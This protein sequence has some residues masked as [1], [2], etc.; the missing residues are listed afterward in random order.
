VNVGDSLVSSPA[1]GDITGDAHMEIVVGCVD[2]YIYAFNHQGSQLWSHN[3]GKPVYTT[4]VLADVDND[5][6][7]EVVYTVDNSKGATISVLE[8]ADG[9]TF[10]GSW[11][12]ALAGPGV[13]SP[14][15][16]DV[17]DDNHLEICVVSYGM[18][19]PI[20][21]SEVYLLNSN[22][23]SFSVNWPVTIDTVIVASPVMGD[24]E[25]TPG[26]T[27]EIVAGGL[28]GA[29]YSID[30]GGLV[31]SSAPRVP[32]MIETAPALVNIDKD[33][34]LEIV[35][36]SRVWQ[37][38][39]PPFGRWY[40]YVTAINNTG[41]IVSGWPNGVG[42]WTTSATVPSPVAFGDKIIDGSPN[43]YIHG[44]DISTGDVADGF[45]HYVAGRPMSSAA[46]GDLD[47]DG[48]L[49]IVQGTSFNAVYCLDMSCS[50][51]YRTSVDQDWVMY[52][53]GPERTGCY[54]SDDATAIDDERGATPATT[55]LRS[56]YPNP[57]NP[58]TTIS[59]ELSG[60]VDVNITIYDIAG[61]RVAELQNGIMTGGKHEVVWR[62]VTDA[63]TTAAS[64]VYFCRLSAGDVVQTKKMVLLK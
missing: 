28:N 45:S 27:L 57:F 19:T 14:A 15:V 38:T 37:E 48:Y 58:T 40:G 25:S 17:N 64:G 35:V 51:D 44:W 3:A 56:V 21:H 43:G 7:R 2:G 62:G 4:P 22:G 16:G 55:A 29:V 47:G 26:S 12:L 11:P 30:T 23:S 24:V 5:G 34:Y 6:K 39:M 46:V 61:R 10:P 59:F 31:W 32:G 50:S 60:N 33:E 49:E 36:G 8:G 1:V 42:S 52:R 41:S 54:G 63:G 9:S 13:T 18:T 20:P 53:S